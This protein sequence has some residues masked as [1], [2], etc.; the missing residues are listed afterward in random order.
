MKNPLTK[1]K[2]KEKN[3]YIMDNIIRQN[4]KKEKFQKIKVLMIGLIN[5]KSCDIHTKNFGV[6]IAYIL[7]QG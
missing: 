2:T 6:Q 4:F 3:R 7:K 5:T 1:Y